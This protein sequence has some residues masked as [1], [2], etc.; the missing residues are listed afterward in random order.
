MASRFHTDDA[1]QRH[2]ASWLDKDDAEYY[3]VT[4]FELPAKASACLLIRS[5]FD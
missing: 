1:K 2:G 3:K 5:K 4:Q